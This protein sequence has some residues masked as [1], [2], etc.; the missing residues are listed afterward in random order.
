MNLY[1][2]ASAQHRLGG[3][4]LDLALMIVTCGIGWIIWSL[5]VWGQGLTPAKQILKLRVVGE[6]ERN[7]ASWGHMAIRQLLIPVTFGI[8]GW[9]FQL[10]AGFNSGFDDAYSSDPFAGQGLALLGS[11]IGLAITLIDA[12]WILKGGQL[13]RVT[14]IW[15]KTIVVNEANPISG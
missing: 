2:K 11:L 13:K 4:F 3:Y 10:L 7:N 12:L 5:I 8:P 6:V 15:A 1:P 14:D 9:I